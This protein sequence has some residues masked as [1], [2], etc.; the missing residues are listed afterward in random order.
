MNRVH[1]RWV[2]MRANRAAHF[3]HR[4]PGWRNRRRRR[5]LVRLF[6]AADGVCLLT[7]WLAVLS[8]PVLVWPCLA[9]LGL[10]LV[11]AAC[12]I[13]IKVL[14]SELADRPTELLDERELADRKS[15]V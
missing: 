12:S 10:F 8:L 11:T 13:A 4:W 3:E 1:R 9:W 2:D 14:T 15:V 5:L 7:G 6:L